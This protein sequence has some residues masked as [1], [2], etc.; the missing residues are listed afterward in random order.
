MSSV[1]ALQDWWTLLLAPVGS[2]G[3]RVLGPVLL[4]CRLPSGIHLCCSGLCV[5]SVPQASASRVPARW[6]VLASM[7]AVAIKSVQDLL[8]L[9]HSLWIVLKKE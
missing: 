9:C 3:R 5:G 8:S 4:D 6:L 2:G 7:E 1:P